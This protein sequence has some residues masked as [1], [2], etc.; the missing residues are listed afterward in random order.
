MYD[1]TYAIQMVMV[2]PYHSPCNNNVVSHGGV[3]Q[4]YYYLGCDMAKTKW[5]L[6]VVSLH[7]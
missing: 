7:F 6:R 3:I 5:H 2:S 1:F 4:H